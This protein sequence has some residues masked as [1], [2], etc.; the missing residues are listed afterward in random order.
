MVTRRVLLMLPG[1]AFAQ[2]QT[3]TPLERRADALAKTD[4]KKLARELLAAIQKDPNDGVSMLLLGIVLA[5]S[6]Q[7]RAAE[8][9]REVTPLYRDAAS[10]LE[11]P[12]DRAAVIELEASLAEQLKQTDEAKALRKRALE[13]RQRIASEMFPSAPT[14]EGELRKI[15]NGVTP[16][17]LKKKHEPKYSPLARFA[18]WQGTAILGLVVGSDGLPHDIRLVR[19]LGLGLDEHAVEA[20][21]G[22]R[23]VPGMLEGDP[24][25]VQATV[26]VN[27]R[28]L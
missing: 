23:F 10:R 17:K 9:T 5:E 16:P 4:R 24:V 26:E 8:L 18:N 11:E 20:V 25:N 2:G 28:M 3:R 27:F 6:L 14:P 15:G 22:W 7:G 21:R 1:L 19:G 12:S 13:I